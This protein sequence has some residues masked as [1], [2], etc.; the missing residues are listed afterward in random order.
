VPGFDRR[1][2]NGEGPM[3]GRGR[4]R[5]N[6][7]NV[8][9]QNANID[10]TQENTPENQAFNTPDYGYGRGF[11]R[12]FGIRKGRGRGRGFGRCRW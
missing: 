2:P 10:N 4:G 5:C 6:G 12:G 9:A 7:V 11:G 1:G 3:T 8:N